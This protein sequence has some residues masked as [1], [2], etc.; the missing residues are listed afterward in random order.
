MNEWVKI[1]KQREKT[2]DFYD[3]IIILLWLASPEQNI[4]N[5]PNFVSLIVS[6]ILSSWQR[7]YSV[8]NA[9]AAGAVKRRGE[10]ESQ[11]YEK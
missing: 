5:Q 2:V 7:S 8:E 9:A 10:E 1:I 4:N 3:N 11:P 6:L